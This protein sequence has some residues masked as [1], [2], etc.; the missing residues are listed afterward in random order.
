MP[1]VTCAS[2]RALPRLLRPRGVIE[3]HRLEMGSRLANAAGR[4]L[5]AFWGDRIAEALVADAA[6]AGTECW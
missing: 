4:D 6:E 5:Y 1:S 2:S 3:P